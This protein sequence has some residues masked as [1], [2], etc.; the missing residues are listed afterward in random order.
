MKFIFTNEKFLK[1]LFYSLPL[2][3][4]IGQAAVSFIFIFFVI[5]FFLS[6]KEISFLY[7]DIIKRLLILYFL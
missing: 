1:I 7:D 3:Y 2:S 4:C 5:I 6:Y